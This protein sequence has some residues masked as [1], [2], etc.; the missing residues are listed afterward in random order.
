MHIFLKMLTSS[1]R[2]GTVST[3]ASAL[4]GLGCYRTYLSS[5]D[6]RP[7]VAEDGLFGRFLLR[8]P[9][10]ELLDVL[11]EEGRGLSFLPAP[12][13]GLKALCLVGTIPAWG[14]LYPAEGT[15]NPKG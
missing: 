2:L 4:W 3:L 5:C 7:P 8:D 11:P 6:P 9:L 12:N 15:V 1:S 13:V 14:C 10:Q